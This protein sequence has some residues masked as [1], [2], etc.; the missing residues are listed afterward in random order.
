[1]HLNGVGSTQ[2]TGLGEKSVSHGFP[3][4]QF[5]VDSIIRFGFACHSSNGMFHLGEDVK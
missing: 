4:Y 2:L 5:H 3:C 1:M